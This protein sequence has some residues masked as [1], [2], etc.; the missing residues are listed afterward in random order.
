MLHIWAQPHIL[1]IFFWRNLQGVNLI[2]ITFS[3]TVQ[4]SKRSSFLALCS[5]GCPFEW[6]MFVTCN[7]AGWLFFAMHVIMILVMWNHMIM[8]IVMY[9]SQMLK[10]TCA[11]FLFPTLHMHASCSVHVPDSCSVPA[12][13]HD[14]CSGLYLLDFAT[15]ACMI[16]ALYQYICILFRLY[17]THVELCMILSYN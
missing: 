3:N 16:L 5:S 7:W 13:V 14:S 15:H 11:W 1:D 17:C 12:H 2:I 4:N 9:N 6:C 10:S 8:I